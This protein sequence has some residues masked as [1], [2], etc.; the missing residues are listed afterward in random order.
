MGQSK[1]ANF[2]QAEKAVK[3]FEKK[4]KDKTKNNWSDRVNFVY[5]SGKY[6]LIEVDGEQDAEVKVMLRQ[7]RH[8][9]IPQDI[10]HSSNLASDPRSA[11]ARSSPCVCA[12]T[13]QV[14]SVD[15]KS[16]KVSKNI[17][18][19]TLNDATKKLVELIFSN[20]MF[21]E[22]MECMNLGGCVSER[23]FL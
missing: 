4:F 17:L 10:S 11:S 2:D 12:L 18:P 23:T 19:C 5:H 9:K 14:D 1:L 20:D 7:I 6:T 15:G 22:A 13:L 21:K 16:V 3:D 8:N